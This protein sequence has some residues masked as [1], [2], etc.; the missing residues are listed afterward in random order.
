M[1]SDVRLKT[2]TQFDEGAF[3][4][5]WVRRMKMRLG[6]AGALGCVVLLGCGTLSVAQADTFN[7]STVISNLSTSTP[8]LAIKGETLSG[9][10]TG[11][12]IVPGLISFSGGALTINGIAVTTTSVTG[13]AYTTTGSGISFVFSS[14]GISYIGN[15]TPTYVSIQGQGSSSSLNGNST[16]ST[17]TFAPHGSAP[18][19]DGAL[20]PQIA[21]LMGCLFVIAKGRKFGRLSAAADRSQKYYTLSPE[22]PSG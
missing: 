2:N 12:T 13:T 19:I 4:M 11:T 15:T 6:I 10:F 14:G 17:Y 1:A 8:T 5:R 3:A 21:A 16:Y 9:T 22:N 18:E 20:I 7:F